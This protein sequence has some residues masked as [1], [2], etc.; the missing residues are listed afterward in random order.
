M[1]ASL[2]IS[3]INLL[4]AGVIAYWLFKMAVKVE[5]KYRLLLLFFGVDIIVY[6]LV[7]IIFAFDNN[8]Q[9]LIVEGANMLLLLAI[10]LA[11]WLWRQSY[12]T[13]GYH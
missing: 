9:P 1:E 5:K 7:Y 6:A 2:I 11:V 12:G 10:T 4:L 13:D 3:S 8:I